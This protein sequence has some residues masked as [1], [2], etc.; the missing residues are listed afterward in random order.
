MLELC[1]TNGIY[2]V[3]TDCVNGR[4]V[5]RFVIDVLNLSTHMQYTLCRRETSGAL[6]ALCAAGQSNALQVDMFNTS[7]TNRSPIRPFT[8]SVSTL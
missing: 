2:R 5:E 1:S 6:A 4:I 8:Q 7:I 3:L